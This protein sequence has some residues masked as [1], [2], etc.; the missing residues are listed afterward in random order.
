MIPG[1]IRVLVADDHPVV[2]EGLRRILDAAPGLEVTG[3]ARSGTEVLALLEQFS[4]DVLVLDVAMPGLSGLEVI[5]EVRQRHPSVTILVLSAHPEDQLAVRA[6]KTGASGYLNKE[7]APESLVEAIRKVHGGGKYLSESLAGALV[8]SLQQSP[9]GARPHEALS[10]REYTVMVMIASG[11]T[12]SE[13]GN[14]LHLSVKTISTYRSRILLKMGMR[15]NAELT[16]YA[17]QNGLVT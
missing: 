4:P 12:V 14:E 16:R 2:L 13:I 5:A 10:N 15:T 3:A 11:K 17:F 6:L 1:P 9:G 7:S 8:E